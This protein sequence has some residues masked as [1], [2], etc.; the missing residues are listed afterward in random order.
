LS[1]ADSFRQLIRSENAAIFSRSIV[2]QI[3]GYGL[4]LSLTPLAIAFYAPT[5]FGLFAV[6]FF[7]ANLVG[8]YG[9]LKLEWAIINENSATAA[10]RLLRFSLT[11][12]L[13][14][15][16]TAAITAA[17]IP[18][19]MYANLK[20]DQYMALLA[21]PLAV[22]IGF[23]LF[24]QS[25]G[26][27]TKS[28]SYVYLSRNA[29]MVSRQIFQ[30]GL[31]LIWPSAF[32]LLLAEFISRLI[33]VVIIL[34]KLDQRIKFLTPARFFSL[35]GPLPLGRYGHYTKIALP[36]SLVD[37]LMT[38]GL[39]VIFVPLYG[40]DI[41][42]AYWLVQRIFG[43][44]IAL[45]GTVAADI[46]QGQI[47]RRHDHEAIFKQMTQVTL[48]LTTFSVIIMPAAAVAFWFF[49]WQLYGGKWLL[50]GQ[51]ALYL[52]PVICTQFV[53]SPISRILIVREKMNYKYI[54]DGTMFAGLASW[55][56]LAQLA[57]LSFWQSIAFLAG[58]QTFAH[59]VYIFLCFQVARRP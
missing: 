8:T 26:I 59:C 37:F 50:S 15:G 33:G 24:V 38:E 40:L 14:W 6:A 34:K 16:I 45:I 23:G 47:A 7:C 19:S 12:I 29:A 28:Y 42:G 46:F 21:A 58:A 27:R 35:L 53:A 55:L 56:L 20:F 48:L 9:G 18:Q 25:W 39:A 54:F 41:A 57:N 4:S 13:A 2:I 31:G 1:I 5:D 30:I 51:L 36:S 52:V 17:L 3:V 32:S 10:G 22:T 43:I 49:T 44:P 11:L